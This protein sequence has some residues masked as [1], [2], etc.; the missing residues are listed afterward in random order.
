MQPVLQLL[1]T[2]EEYYHMKK[3]EKE[4]T[5]E[6]LLQYAYKYNQIPVVLFAKDTQARYIYT[7]EIEDLINGGREHSILGK[8]DREI[9]YDPQ[10]GQLFYEQDLEIVRTGNPCH[11]YSEFVKDGVHKFLEVTKNPFY[12]DDQLIGVC[13]AASDV[14]E[15][16]HLRK[17][18]E[19]LSVIDPLTSLYNRNFT[20]KLDLE[21]E[22][23]LPCS[24][25]FCDCNG[26]KQVNDQFGHDSGDFYLRETSRILKEI[27]PPSS[28][29][30]R[31]GGDE[32]VII[33]PSCPEDMHQS[34]LQAIKDRQKCFSQ[35]YAF[36]GLA[37]G[38]ALRTDLRVSEA[39]ILKLADAQMYADKKEGH[40][41]HSSFPVC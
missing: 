19:Q 8:T 11:C 10:L 20:V 41:H 14:T 33:T 7:S 4:Y 36:A 29:V 24:Y 22:S 28:H 32:F 18:Y 6:E 26:L 23:A 39:E 37:V 30:I 12:A 1:S 13:G 17:K 27:A 34:L 15:L 38:G 16:I 35:H 21:R 31:W 40:A 5:A 2:A 25:I 9:Q 3:S